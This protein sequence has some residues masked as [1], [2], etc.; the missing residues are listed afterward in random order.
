MFNKIKMLVLVFTVVG[1][2]LT[3]CGQQK[4]TENKDSGKASQTETASNR[5]NVLR[6]GIAKD[7][8]NLN[9]VLV[10]G[11]YGEGVI[12][13]IFDTLV[14]FKEDA[15]NPAP[16]LAEKWEISEDGKEYTFFLKKGV[17]FHNG[18]ELKASDVKFTIEAIQNPD[19]A[20]PSKEFFEP[21]EKIEI[22]DDYS[23][24]FTLSAPYAPFMMALGTPTVGILPEKYV[25]EVGMEA[26]DRKPIGSGAFKF[27]EWVP[28]DHITLVANKDYFIA[29]PN[30][31]KVI[32]RPIP[33]A[34]VMSAELQSGG[35]DI[36]SELSPQDL[37]KLSGKE[38]YQVKSIPGLSLKYLGFS[39][40]Q[41]PYSDVRFRQAVYYAVPFDDVVGGIF[42]GVGERAY[43]WIPPAVFPNDNAYMKEK[44]LP[45]NKE[46]AKEL[47]NE[48]KEEGILE[49]GFSFT[50]YSPQDTYRKNVA[51][52]VATSLLEYGLKPE[53]QSLEWGTLLPA[54]EGGKAGMYVLGWGSVPDPDR[55]TYK[56]FHS[57]SSA[58]SN[59]SA[60]NNPK[61]DEALVKGRNLTDVTERGEQYKIAMRTALTEDYIHIPLAFSNVSVAMGKDV[62]EF[63]P[64]PQGYFHL[65][66]DKR[67][68]SVK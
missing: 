53:V 39:A 8:A 27:E 62:K 42:K 11:L 60:Y 51:T 9:P 22:L 36:A 35:I 67:N 19:N 13:N 61:V 23:I 24:K 20:S 2:L 4:E 63:E 12:G 10:T 5:E 56:L 64:S 18:D 6:I 46:K 1:V 15:S 45:Y 41:L 58:K 47:F 55:W 33:K 26:F 59:R 57:E 44:A 14:S 40:N 48:L 68:V 37:E 3:G 54:T 31:D 38:D 43:S 52:A 50:I 66:T 65:V 25:T 17:K 7:P 28:D 30:V 16:L 49:E 29:A 32:F 21:V 34:E